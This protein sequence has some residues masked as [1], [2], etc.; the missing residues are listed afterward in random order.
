MKLSFYDWC[1]QNERKDLLDRW[2]YIL[3]NCSPKDVSYGSR[4]DIYFIC[5]KEPSHTSEKHRISH[6][7]NMGIDIDCKQCNSFYQWCIDNSRQDLIDTWDYDLN[8]DDIHLVP[9]GSGKKFYFCIETN[10]PSIR[11]ALCEITGY[12]QLCP[13]KKFYNS[14]GYWLVSTYGYTAIEKY[15]SDKNKRT[16]WDYDKGSGKYVWFKCLEKDYHDDYFSQI[17]HFVKGSRCPWCAG[18][19]IHPLDSFA[20]YNVNKLGKDFLEKYWCTDNTIDPWS[21]RPFTNGLQVHIQCQ[22]KDYHQYWVEVA[23]YSIGVDCPFCNRSRLHINDSLGV[24]YPK[25][26]ILWSDKN[27]MSPYDYHPHSHKFAWWKCE[28]GIHEDYIRRIADVTSQG[29]D[30]CSHCVRAEH[31]SSFQKEVRLFLENMSYQLLHEFDCNIIPINPNT[32]QKMPF[33]NELCEVYGKNL[34]IETHG[35]QHYELGGWHI[36]RAKQRGI[37]PIEEFEYQKWKDVFKREFAIS[38]GYEY[39]EV[40]YWTIEDG[41][42]KNLILDKINQI[43]LQYYKNA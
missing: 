11:Y 35:I 34:I 19:K 17:Y 37:T 28:N 2:D 3:N 5:D 43:K 12:K 32:K 21:I 24:L 16:P 4:K 13:I 8:K 7:T 1:I 38:N 29:F 6:I 36:T 41:T 23:D 10:M 9:Y 20:Q 27:E 25:T 18:K 30:R 14:F 31:E 40:P 22:H 33:D 42:Y 39:L 26:V 15:W